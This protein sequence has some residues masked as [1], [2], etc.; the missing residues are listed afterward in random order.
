MSGFQSWS[1]WTRVKETPEYKQ[2]AADMR[3]LE[4]YRAPAAAYQRVDSPTTKLYAADLRAA[5]QVAAEQAARMA[6]LEKQAKEAGI[7][8]EQLLSGQVEGENAEDADR[9]GGSPEKHG[10]R[11]YPGQPLIVS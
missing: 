5:E 6:E 4:G 1:E 10:H 7:T 3:A 9:E 11:G 2:H 8:V